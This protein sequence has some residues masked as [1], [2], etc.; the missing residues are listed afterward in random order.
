MINLKTRGKVLIAAGSLAALTV[1][2]SMRFLRDIHAARE[3]V[4]ALGSQMIETACGPIEYTSHGEGYPV[5]VIHAIFGGFDQGIA[6]AG[7]TFEGYRL[8]VP[9][10]FGYLRTPMPDNASPASQS[11]AH[12]CLLDSLGI[13]RAAVIGYSAGATSAIQFALRYP[14]R[15]SAL[16]LVSPNAPGKEPPLPPRTVM[17]LLFKTDFVFWLAT[18]YFP[19]AI[20]SPMGVPK[21]LMLTPAEEAEVATMMKTVLPAKPRGAGYL[22]DMY[23]SNPDINTGYPFAEI[24]A[25]VLVVSARDDPT[26]PYENAR[27]LT[28]QIPRARLLTIER[29]GHLNLGQRA[30]IT[31]EIRA[32]LREQI[33][34]AADEESRFF[35]GA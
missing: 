13:E 33:S 35:V 4:D 23:V 22:F 25:P 34:T 27:S 8:I 16:V 24:T 26:A 3:R 1:P 21:E 15:V 12:A 11:D 6:S 30:R 14:E 32:F 19:N 29:G 2:L 7:D 31:P 9:S 20:R 17:G 5:L 10:R 28:E 18:T